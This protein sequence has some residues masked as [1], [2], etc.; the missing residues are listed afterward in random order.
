VTTDRAGAEKQLESSEQINRERLQ[1]GDQGYMAHLDLAAVGSIRGEV[2]SASRSLKAAKAAG[3]RY[4][5][6]AA[7]DPLFESLRSD[8]E[9]QSLVS[10]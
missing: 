10:A 3:W 8:D 6:I 2:R 1:A 5:S 9:F 7:R 4:P